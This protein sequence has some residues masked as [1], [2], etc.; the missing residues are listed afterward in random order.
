MPELLRGAN[1]H[2]FLKC[3]KWGISGGRWPH[4]G[5]LAQAAWCAVNW[6]DHLTCRRA[7]GY[8]LKLVSGMVMKGIDFEGYPVYDGSIT[9]WR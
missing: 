6:W 4:A 2:R 8:R 3:A 1:F 9:E 5:V 7:A